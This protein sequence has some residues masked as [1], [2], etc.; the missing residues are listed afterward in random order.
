MMS[1][2]GIYLQRYTGDRD[3]PQEDLSPDEPALLRHPGP[4][5]TQRL[6]LLRRSVLDVY[7][8]TEGVTGSSE[9]FSDEFHYDI[10]GR[11][12]IV[13]FNY[14]N[15]ESHSTR[16]GSEVDVE[17]IKQLFE[18]ELGFDV[19]VQ[20]DLD[21]IDTKIKIPQVG[22][23]PDIACAVVCIGTHGGEEGL[24]LT[25]DDGG[26]IYLKE[27]VVN[28]LHSSEVLRNKPKIIIGE[29]RFSLIRSATI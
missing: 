19:E 28:A 4:E 14:K 12:R 22:N 17:R 8:R 23:A 16:H 3:R 1:D 29:L 7:L 20:P 18:E 26:E 15:F 27:D 11:K 10:K 13:I 24:L 25:S 6:K 21:E 2:Y 5:N 9:G